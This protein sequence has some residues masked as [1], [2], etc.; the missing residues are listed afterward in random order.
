[1]RLLVGF[2]VV[3]IVVAFAARALAPSY[4]LYDFRRSTLLTGPSNSRAVVDALRRFGI[5]VT[6]SRVPLFPVVADT[7]AARRHDAVLLLAPPRAPTP[8]E[9][10]GLVNY[11]RSG[12]SLVLV[13]TTVLHRFGWR[14]V[15]ADTA[16]RFDTVR[17]ASPRGFEKLPA[18]YAVLERYRG[19]S[20]ARRGTEGGIPPVLQ[21]TRVDTL[22]T[23]RD[24]RLVAA[25]LGFGPGAGQVLAIAESRL[26]ANALWKRTDAG[27]LVTSWLL[28]LGAPRMVVDEYH[29]GF[30]N[31]WAIVTAA[32]SWL[33]TAPA[34]WAMLQ[35][36]AVALV[37][38]AVAAM[39]FGPI[40][41][42][43]RRERRSPLEHA[44]ALGA[45]LERAG[46]S[47]AA[48]ELLVEGLRRRLAG[49]S[50]HGTGTRGLAAWLDALA[51]AA[52]RPDVRR[53]A[54][55]LGALMRERGRERTLEAAQTVEDVW[56]ALRRTPPGASA[57]PSTG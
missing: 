24:G 26:V 21:A 55:R 45:G 17:V 7:A 40:V 49:A 42:V 36:A 52:D 29:Q 3:A 28:D 23:T 11:V 41:P 44:E 50:P 37:A 15:A 53:G 27:T 38:L 33:V 32:W 20:A 34:G 57:T 19:D 25:R 4:N 5:G 30:G 16:K 9:L 43:I 2:T 47:D 14:A 18:T 8:P 54:T 31:P 35:L 56:E 13:A 1:M 46:G 22:L 51:R 10:R 12:G 48:V 6:R 39:R